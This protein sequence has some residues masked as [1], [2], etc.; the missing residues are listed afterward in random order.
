MLRTNAEEP[1]FFRCCATICFISVFQLKNIARKIKENSEIINI[2]VCARARHG[3]REIRE[4]ILFAGTVWIFPLGHIS[5]TCSQS[6]S[7]TLECCMLYSGE[8]KCEKSISTHMQYVQVC[9]NNRT[10]V[11]TVGIYDSMVPCI[12]WCLC[13]R[14]RLVYGR[15]HRRPLFTISTH[16]SLALLLS[17][18][19]NPLPFLSL[20]DHPRPY[21]LP[22]TL[23]HLLSTQLRS[24]ARCY[25]IYQLFLLVRWCWRWLCAVENIQF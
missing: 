1:F 7:D 15:C 24:S 2:H 3:C 23:S 8:N 21:H 12:L 11:W 17:P 9:A 20:C 25:Y 4:S 14:E 10:N 19:P 22:S 5:F 16:L 6:Y 18:S 13:S